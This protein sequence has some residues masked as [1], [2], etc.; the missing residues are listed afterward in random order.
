[1]LKA[2][3]YSVSLTKPTEK[4]MQLKQLTLQNKALAI[5]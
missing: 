5:S 4:E 2:Y 1:M 3:L